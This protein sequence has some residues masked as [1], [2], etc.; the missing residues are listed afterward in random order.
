MT[1]SSILVIGGAGKTG[2]AIVAEAIR[3][4]LRVTVLVRDKA[5][6]SALPPGVGVVE[7]D[8]RN[9]SALASA[10]KGM[11]AVVIP[12]GGRKD[13]VSAQVVAAVLPLMKQQGI[14]RLVALSAYGA[15]DGRGFYGWLMKTAAK[16]VVADKVEME[17]ILR[18]SDLDWTAVRPGV[19]TDGRATG[20]VTARED[21]VLKGMPQISRSD[22]AS[23]ILDEL[24]RPRF[25]G[26]APVISV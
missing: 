21:A 20:S 10:L 17:R 16:A 13:P 14:K 24:E 2:A 6:A 26:R 4:G 19:L 18:A 12:A 22:L 3:R 23:F 11:D 1:P 9:A 7:G 25:I 5:K 8:G 15:V